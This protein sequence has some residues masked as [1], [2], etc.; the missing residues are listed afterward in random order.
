VAALANGD[1]RRATDLVLDLPAMQGWDVALARVNLLARLGRPEEAL[2]LL[3]SQF[4]RLP[5][6]DPFEVSGVARLR[7]L[8]RAVVLRAELESRVGSRDEALQWARAAE[9]LLSTGEEVAEPTLQ[10]IRD[11]SASQDAR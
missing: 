10:R 2:E 6:T 11:I 5:V 7:A 4:A 9:V 1:A 3:R 8:G